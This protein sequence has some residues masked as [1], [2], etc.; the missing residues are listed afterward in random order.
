M[1]FSEPDQ[2]IAKTVRR[3]AGNPASGI[4]ASVFTDKKE[5][6]IWK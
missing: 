1:V 3:W 4:K 2:T 6:V 5:A